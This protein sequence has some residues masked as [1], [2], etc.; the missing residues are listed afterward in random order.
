MSWGLPAKM[1]ISILC[2]A[3]AATPAAVRDYHANRV[4]AEAGMCPFFLVAVRTSTVIFALA[5]VE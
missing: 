2:P 3:R 1:D 4:V 5:W